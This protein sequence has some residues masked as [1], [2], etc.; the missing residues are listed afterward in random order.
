MTIMTKI[1]VDRDDAFAWPP[2][3]AHTAPWAEHV[4]ESV[5]V[6]FPPTQEETCGELR[7]VH[8][9]VERYAD[10]APGFDVPC[11]DYRVRLM[12]GP[13]TARGWPD[14]LSFD[15][16]AAEEL[17][18]NLSVAVAATRAD[19]IANRGFIEGTK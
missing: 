5:A 7:P 4:D 17:A 16:D 9:S 3:G 19:L 14:V 10:N 6:G 11:L 13:E 1:I 12:V 15:L 8:I 2:I 18:H